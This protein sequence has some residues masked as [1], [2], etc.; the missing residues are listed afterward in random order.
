MN[1][2]EFLVQ[3]Q[4]RVSSELADRLRDV[5]APY[6]QEELI[7]AEIVMSHMNDVDIIG[8]PRLSYFAGKVG[9]ANLRLVGY[10]I[11]DDA[12]TLDL[13]VSLYGGVRELEAIETA[14]IRQAADQCFMFLK[15]CVEGK[16]VKRLDQTSDV[17]DIASVIEQTYNDLDRIRI[18][19]ITDRQA[20]SAS[21]AF[22]PVV[23]KGKTISM[24]IM[25]IERLWR[26]WSAGKPRDELIVNFQEMCGD[27]LPCVYV[28]G[29]VASYD[30]ALAAIPAE[31]LHLLYERFGARLL[32]A[33][34]RSFLSATGKVN[35]GMRD[36]LR[37]D[38]EDFM[39]F[40]NGIVMVA[41][42]ANVGRAADGSV[43]LVAL[44]GMQIVNGG[45]TTASIY[46]TKKK[47]PE[48]DLSRV[49]VAAKIIVLQSADPAT[50]EQMIS[51]ISKYANSQ[52]SVKQSDLSAN[53]PF[54]IQLEKLANTT[55]CPDG[56]SQWFYERA[57]G[58]YNVKL[59]REG[60][61]PARLKALKAA[62]PT[63]RKIA[64]TDL[65]K[66]L[67]AWGRQPDAVSYG[68]QKNFLR[69]MDE[70][71]EG[72]LD[73][74]EPLTVTWYKRMVAQAIIFKSAQKL[75]RARHFAQAQANIA[76]YLVSVLAEELGDRLDLD[77][78][79]N[80]QEISPQLLRLMERWALE[81][82]AAL[83]SNAGPR[84]IS[85]QAKRP[86]CWD[87]VRAH[88]FSEP[89]A[90]IPELTS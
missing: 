37:Q 70:L 44:K 48:T 40:N 22:K 29:Q 21:K 81:V 9:N 49:R 74:P 24:E 78:I 41:D 30:Y 63:T 54:H 72:K 35:R 59:A 33:N 76:A 38:P 6:P 46:F 10:A 12:D 58:S 82:E 7:F 68:S 32:E 79:W 3:T 77:R 52:N 27:A 87:A 42:E 28:P 55:Y 83:R 34:V 11:S 60:T 25:D 85:E 16:L 65:A 2:D 75:S 20:K 88:P 23:V 8:E 66:Y 18:F 17:F 14:E 19:V 39:A 26:H 56:V 61:T 13:V 80:R 67:N 62:I 84:M 31:V 45:Q 15:T 57:A 64:K 73:I 89:D 86:E 4:D 69:F 5:S 50:E 47:N 53:K 43:G 36:T 51:D 1:L 90:D 71:S